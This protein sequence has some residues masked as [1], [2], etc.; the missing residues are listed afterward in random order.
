MEAGGSLFL[1]PTRL[2]TVCL[3]GISFEQVK[4]NKTL[5]QLRHV[6]CSPRGVPEPEPSD[7]GDPIVCN[8]FGGRAFGDMSAQHQC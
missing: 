6:C 2:Q 8:S 1:K 7:S 5:S 4:Q 3:R